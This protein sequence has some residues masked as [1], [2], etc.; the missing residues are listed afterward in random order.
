MR[1]TGS[2]IAGLKDGGRDHE[3][4]WPLEPETVKKWILP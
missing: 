1:G 3:P 4:P 2:P